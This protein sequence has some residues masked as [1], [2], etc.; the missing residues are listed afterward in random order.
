MEIEPTNFV[1]KKFKDTLHFY[2]LLGG[3][4]AAVIISIISVRANPELTEVPDGYEPRHW[5]YYRHPIA[6]FVARYVFYPPELEDEMVM[7]A[8]ED[9]SENAIVRSV[10]NKV[11]E[12]M[13]FY[14]DHRSSY[15]TPFYAEMFRV[16][17]DDEEYGM[18]FVFSSEGKHYDSAY[19]PNFNPV[20][21]EG[22]F[23]RSD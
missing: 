2:T 11:E 17:R 15:F 8:T 19:D 13:R 9:V 14:N 21:T 10:Q 1:W 23:P 16:A 18:N 20:P 4:P 5:E 6:R 3:I 22:Y 7:H 12:A